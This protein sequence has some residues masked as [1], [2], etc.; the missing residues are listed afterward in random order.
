MSWTDPHEDRPVDVEGV[1]SEEDVSAPDAA[2][3]LDEDPE[4]QQNR[5]QAAPRPTFRDSEEPV[6]DEQPDG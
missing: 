6:E 3:R 5:A 2:D 1:P 4:E